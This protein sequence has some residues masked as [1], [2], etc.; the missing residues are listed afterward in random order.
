M[1]AS[2]SALIA[3]GRQLGT[4]RQSLLALALA[5]M[6]V[7][8]RLVIGRPW[9]NN[10]ALWA[11]VWGRQILH[12]EVPTFGISQSSTPHPLTNLLAAMVNVPGARAGYWILAYVGLAAFAAILALTFNLARRWFGIAAGLVA[13]VVIASSPAFVA[14]AGSAQM[15]LLFVALVLAALSLAVRGREVAAMSALA[16]AGL[17]RPEAWVFSGAFLL[18]LWACRTPGL[19]RLIIVAAIAPVVWLLADLLVTGNPLYALTYTQEEAETLGRTTG[20]TEVPSAARLGLARLLT[21]PGLLGGIVG[22]VAALLAR[23]ALPMLALGAL[24]GVIFVGY[25]IAGVSLLDRYL[26]LGAIVL[27]VMLGHAL[28]GW[29]RARG[30]P[31]VAWAGVACALLLYGVTGLSGRAA[32]LRFERARIQS[33]AAQ[34]ADLDRLLQQP[35]SARLLRRCRL[36]VRDQRPVALLLHQVGRSPHDVVD[37]RHAR[38]RPRDAFV[39]ATPEAVRG[40]HLGLFPDLPESE[41]APRPTEFAVAIRTPRWE[42][43][44]AGGCRHRDRSK[45]LPG[46]DQAW[47]VPH[48]RA[49]GGPRADPP[50]A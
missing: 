7:A 22:A 24:T 9:V 35:A 33:S 46:V 34:V 12:G 32:A 3:R 36:L 10:D 18:W 21:T 19:S 13:V 49:G 40:N 16:A 50:S 2:A 4:R 1:R 5:A 29:M 43:S 14:A 44:T 25:G 37:A 30:A 47:Y 27:A 11:L 8:I 41:L 38:R 17:M 42:L 45:N 15:D 28:T 6:T 26:L 39:T 20:V 23:R 48:V 31:R